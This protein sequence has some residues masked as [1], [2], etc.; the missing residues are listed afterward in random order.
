[1]RKLLPLMYRNVS[2]RDCFGIR[3]YTV[4]LPLLF[5]IVSFVTCQRVLFSDRQ[6]LKLLPADLMMSMSVD[7]YSSFLSANEV[8]VGTPDAIRLKRVGNRIAQSSEKLLGEMGKKDWIA[9]FDWQFNLVK[10]DAANAWCMP[11][12]KV[13]FYTGILPITKDEVGMAVVMS[14]EIAHALA[15][16]G[17]ERMSQQMAQAVG[18]TALDIAL[19]EKPQQTRDLF[20]SAYGIGT[21]VGLTLPYSRLQ[22]SE[23][24]EIGLYL[25]ANAG[26]DP[27][28]APEFWQRM[29]QMSAGGQGPE[30]LSTHPSHETRIRN[31]NQKYMARAVQ[32]YNA[33]Q[34]QP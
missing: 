1:M 17:N 21:T 8:V 33:S 26:Y 25:M 29:Q 20:L 12:G 7:Q 2:N 11:G 4:L 28:E 6:Q 27:R 18:Y 13:V 19:H 15:H 31:M 14:H 34:L 9:N 24:D 10:D 16:H 30:F 23:A 22:E 3:A 32:Y 5:V